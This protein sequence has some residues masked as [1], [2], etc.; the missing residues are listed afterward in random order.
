M[1]DFRTEADVLRDELVRRRDF[2]QYPELAF[3]EVR[4][5]GIIADELRLL[6]LETQTGIGQTGIV[7]ILEGE[8]DGPTVLVRSDMDGLPIQ[9]DNETD[10]ASTTLGKMHACGHDGHMV[11]VLGVAKLLNAH[12]AEENVSG[13]RAMIADG[14]L[15]ALCPDVTL[16]LH[17][18]NGLPLGQLGV[19]DGAIL[20]GDSIFKLTIIGYGGH[21]AFPLDT[22]VVIVTQ[23]IA[24]HATNII[25]EQVELSGAF[26][27]FR[28]EVADLVEQRIREISEGLCSAMGCKIEFWF[29]RGT[30][31]TVNDRKVAARVPRAFLDIA[32][33]GQLDLMIRTTASED[34][35][36]F[37]TAHPDKA[38][39][40]FGELSVRGRFSGSACANA[41]P[42]R[43]TDAAD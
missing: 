4:T 14:V 37:V 16:G 10:Y 43:L 30:I 9:E 32:S 18:W 7:G 21:A 31:P 38:N 17:I 5:G 13:A 8:Q 23:M 2:H 25:P 27:V 40:R 29:N 12:P 24:G 11:I 1:I 41:L 20:T 19:A 28:T 35:A 42:C 15:G 39:T 36:Y 3:E 22:A 6:G 26:R 34:V 33:E